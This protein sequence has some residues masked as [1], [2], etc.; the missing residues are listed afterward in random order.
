MVRVIFHIKIHTKKMSGIE[1]NKKSQVEDWIEVNKK[2]Q[3][4][5]LDDEDW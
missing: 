2:S 5:D 1:V 3:V 4:I